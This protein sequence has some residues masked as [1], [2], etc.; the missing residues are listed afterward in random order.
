MVWP[1]RGAGAAHIMWKV[2]I[3]LIP[4]YSALFIV[5]LLYPCLPNSQS[6][7]D[8]FP[9]MSHA[10]EHIYIFPRCVSP[11]GRIISLEQ[12]LSF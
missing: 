6:A 10:I 11:R 12:T 2:D 4:L 9:V 8:V 3:M 5:F 7:Q 1:G